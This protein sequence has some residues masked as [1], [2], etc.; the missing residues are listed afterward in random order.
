MKNI[1]IATAL[2]AGCVDLAPEQSYSE[3]EQAIDDGTTA[4]AFQIARAVQ[5]F[6]SDFT[7]T[8]SGTQIAD[9]VVLTALHCLPK[10][11]DVVGFWDTATSLIGGRWVSKVTIP[12]GTSIDPKDIF[13]SSGDLA[14][15]AVVM[16]S[17]PAPAGRSN[18]TLAWVHPGSDID[19]VE[20]GS[21]V[22]DDGEVE[23]ATS[24]RQRGDHTRNGQF[25][26]AFLTEEGAT[27]YG[28]SG[29]PTY[30][31]TRLLGVLYGW[32]DGHGLHT[33]V[34]HHLQFILDAMGYEWPYNPIGNIRR[35][36]PVITSLY[37]R[38]LDTCAYACD[39]TTSCRAFNFVPNLP[40][41][42]TQCQLLSS[43]DNAT[44][45]AGFKSASK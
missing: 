3:R 26:G 39:R 25:D 20:V 42:G 18:A 5:L 9:D 31:G 33:S 7:P 10:V 28:D 23:R 21:G 14:D 13:D 4:S 2:L 45:V 19:V 16:L 6:R 1:C 37:G 27:D 43:V 17:S 38:A 22:H 41:Y 35:T 11:G 36:G 12:P 15:I 40:V 44:I 24:L 29:G 8:C 30:H 34:P 32:S